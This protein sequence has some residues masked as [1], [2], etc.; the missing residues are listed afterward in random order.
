MSC[1]LLL[2]CRMSVYHMLPKE[3]CHGGVCLVVG[4][5]R[6]VQ[7]LPAAGTRANLGAVGVLLL[8][9]MAIGSDVGC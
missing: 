3:Y 6:F 7:H 4:G 2:S 8:A 9:H 5:S 1:M